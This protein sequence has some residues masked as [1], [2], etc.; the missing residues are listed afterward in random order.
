MARF[1]QV[2]EV[3]ERT[4]ENDFLLLTLKSLLKEQAHNSE[5]GQSSRPGGPLHLCLMSA[6][7]DSSILSDYYKGDFSHVPRVKVSGRTFPVTTI[8]LED[9]L[10]LTRHTVDQGADWCRH[11]QAAQ[12]RA[13]RKEV[14][15][16]EGERAEAP[17]SESDFMRRFPRADTSV[18][19]ALAALDLDALN[20]NLVVDLVQWFRR[21]GSLSGAL[22]AAGAKESDRE[23][24]IEG[25]SAD[26]RG[27]AIL[28][29]LPGTKEIEDVKDALLRTSL[30]AQVEQ[31][32]W[33]LP[34][35][36]SLPAGAHRAA[37][38]RPAMCIDMRVLSVFVVP[39]AGR[40]VTK[41]QTQ[42][43]RNGSSSGRRLES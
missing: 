32:A 4:V 42:R 9:A 24:D 39:C 12:R 29:F 25:A 37:F 20:I 13:S 17:P 31:R 41:K 15:R 34:L 16:R 27:E 21:C 3:H 22:R 11:S 2:D 30:C 23:R 40:M 43:S 38:L 19:K 5:G 6:T 33:V 14:S 8:H 28:V 18:C 35:H 7:M 10:H 1:R 36:G 26:R